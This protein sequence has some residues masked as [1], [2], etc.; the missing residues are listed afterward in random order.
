MW[1]LV[2][3]LF[4]VDNGSAASVPA[5]PDLSLTAWQ[6]VVDSS[7][8]LALS[9]LLWLLLHSNS[10]SGEQK[11]S[12]RF[13]SAMVVAIIALG[14][15]HLVLACTFW[16]PSAVIQGLAKLVA[17]IAIWGGALTAFTH[18]RK[19]LKAA[20]MASQNVKQVGDERT[21]TVAP[22]DADELRRAELAL[23]ES[24]AIYSSLVDSLPLNMFRKDLQG[25]HVYANKRY[26]EIL[27]MELEELMYKRDQDL[28]PEEQAKK[29]RMDDMRVISTGRV[30]EDVEEHVKPD[31]TRIYVQV[32][33][34]P[35]KDAAGNTVGLQG[36][37]WDVTAKQ[38]AEE[39]LRAAKEA[40]ETASHAKSLFL[41][42]MS[43]EIRTP[44]NGVIGI[45]ELLLDTELNRNQREL[46]QTVRES[47]ESLLSVINDILDFSKIEVGKLAL[48]REELDL[49]ECL[50]DTVKSLAFRAHA[51]GLEIIYEVEDDIPKTLFGD[52]NRL[53]QVIVNLV[54]NAIKFTEKGE[55]LL[56]V[57]LEARRGPE[58][59]LHFSVTDTGM[60]VP[61][62][63]LQSI[64]EA[65][66]QADGS[67][68]RQFGGTGLGLAIS[69]N[70]VELMQGRIWV[71]SQVGSGTT[72][73]FTAK[74]EAG[75]EADVS[76]ENQ[77]SNRL[78]KTNVLIVDSNATNR[79]VHHHLF[80]QW[81]MRPTAV[82]SSSEAFQ[83]VSD[84]CRQG[85]PFDLIVCNG[86]MPE[87]DGFEVVQAVTD[88][89]A[90]KS[91]AVIMLLSSAKQ[92]DDVARCERMGISSYL[93][94]PAKPSDLFNTVM[95]ELGISTYEQIG[96]TD[97]SK[98]GEMQ[99]LNILLAEDSVVNQKV[100]IGLLEKHGHRITVANNGREAV[101]LVQSQRFDLVLMDVQ[102]PE[103]D[104]LE[105]TNTIRSWE[106]STGG[107][108]PIVGMTAHAMKGDRD[109]CIRA[110]MDDYVTKPVRAA[111]LFDAI[112][113]TVTNAQEG[114][115]PN[116]PDQE[117]QETLETD[118][119]EDAI[120]WAQAREAFLGDEELLRTVSATFLEELP[121][122]MQAVHAANSAGNHSELKRAAHTLKGS[123]GYCG[124]QA[125]FDL[126]FRLENLAEEGDM[127][128]AHEA[129]DDLNRE[130][131]RVGRALTKFLELPA[132]NSP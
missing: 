51:K 91:A 39:E 129:V 114:G 61:Q 43:H 79:R 33:K 125:A 90:T 126:A 53:R 47:G 92:F 75:R 12:M 60:G 98:T 83:V 84:R 26:C 76:A 34:A 45:T 107:H 68:T 49:R 105:A 22:H 9:V 115:S 111:Q 97:T 65:F 44:L 123:L 95:A 64:F 18:Y 55:V 30:I 16:W 66:E 122:M 2:T 29:Y 116:A 38:Q 110:G 88:H 24:E 124:A 57:E 93:V 106:R 120:D 20:A 27:N 25:R 73:H 131:D 31:G 101:S 80:E 119:D 52:R 113:A 81:G 117:T 99:T 86:D 85:E 46:L 67:T 6:F 72:M 69:S 40:A 17:T 4:H 77:F 36:L 71:E 127:T 5:F 121:G 23:M 54:G 109:R 130:I 8:F 62:D 118:P 35:V 21:N 63:K 102:M 87:G 28:F 132:K 37:F 103:M 14:V 50:G 1:E 19:S 112:V 32:L 11:P 13:S 3:Q 56:S 128:G 100:A 15:S 70:L 74:L 94:K 104:G 108:I 96:E 78:G 89:T 48:E 59:E 82:A 58:V 41:A 42:N 10:R 7:A